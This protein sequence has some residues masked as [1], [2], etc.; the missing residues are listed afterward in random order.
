MSVAWHTLP[1]RN[2]ATHAAAC[3]LMER[4]EEAVAARGQATLA[5]S[6]GSLPR[7]LFHHLAT[8][9]LPW[10]R[11]HLFW[12]DER[13]VAP[14]HADSNYRLARESLLA[15]VHAPS[16]NIHR[17]LGELAPA[18]AAARYVQ[19]LRSFF[20]PA[21]GALPA[22]DVIHLGLGPDCHTASLFP[23]EPL[24]HDRTG[25]AAAV[26]VEKMQNWRVTLLPGVLLA[27]RCILFFTAGAEKA[28]AVR[29][30][31]SAPADPLRFPAQVVTGHHPT[32]TFFLDEPAAMAV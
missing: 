17:V 3:F 16:V 12:V 2:A 32:V 15:S 26:Y 5:I 31:R 11:I 13:C 27:A 18:E 8:L 28:P 21:S 30:L 24:I 6:G 25:L 22:F 7:S 23:G 1:D 20:Q 19:E 10:D 29:A 9:P 14:D 4:L